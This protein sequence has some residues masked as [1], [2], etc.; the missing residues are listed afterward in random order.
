MVCVAVAVAGGGAAELLVDS[1][2]EYAPR[3]SLITLVTPR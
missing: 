3:G 1:L 2:C